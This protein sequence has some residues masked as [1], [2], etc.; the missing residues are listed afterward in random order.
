MFT[1]LPVNGEGTG[2]GQA[3]PRSPRYTEVVH[4]FASTIRHRLAATLLCAVLACRT[5]P[6]PAPQPAAQPLAWDSVVSARIGWLDTNGRRM[7]GKR[8]I[9][10]AP[11]AEMP[12]AWQAA[13]LDSLD[14]GV[15]ALRALIGTHR[16][17]RIGDRPIRYYLLTERM[18]SRA[19]GRD[20]VF[21]SM[22]HVRNGQAPYLHEAAH[23]LLAPPPPF[24]YDE[25]ADTVVAEA[26]FQASP[27]WL[28]EGLPDVLAARAAASAHTIEGDVFTI[29]GL[30]KA[31]ST[32]AA[33][34]AGNPYRAEL[35]RSIGGGG[36]PDALYTPDR[37]KVAPAFYACAQSMANYL[38]DRIG[39][40][41]AVGLFP[42]MKT[43]EWERTF[44]RV[45]GMSVETFR[46][47]WQGRIGVAPHS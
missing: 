10:L 25:F 42:V 20:V 14:R 26:K 27:Y 44:E 6:P 12:E 8:V 9:L 23:E 40:Q 30:D 1:P 46:A 31:D 45:A 28:A 4:P 34:L 2:E 13:L 35:L 32:C 17:Q 36:G 3:I 41:R 5:S 7:A 15:G 37:N 22:Y 24:F 43:G 47:A 38:V 16:W 33:R 29:G 11:P 19:S 18:V 39:M 21:I